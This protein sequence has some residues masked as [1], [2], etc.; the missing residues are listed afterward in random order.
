M[1]FIV[2]ES[3]PLVDPNEAPLLTKAPL[4]KIAQVT[5]PPLAQMKLDLLFQKIDGFKPVSKN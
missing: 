4:T 1:G 5:V 2:F 3:L